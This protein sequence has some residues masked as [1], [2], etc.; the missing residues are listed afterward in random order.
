MSDQIRIEDFEK[1]VFE[2]EGIGIVVR[3]PVGT[4]VGDYP[5]TRA[6]AGNSR[7]TEWLERRVQLAIGDEYDVAI[8][9]GRGSK[10][11]LNMTIE[12]LR[13]TYRGTETP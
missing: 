1:K 9:D 10:P 6:N 4:M 12:T 11:R 8:V 13:A 5:Y 7:I 3:A 2:V